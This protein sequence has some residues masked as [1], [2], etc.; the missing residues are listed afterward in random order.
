MA[1][2]K[3]T[4]EDINLIVETSVKRIVNEVF[5]DDYDNEYDDYDKYDDD[6]EENEPSPVEEYEQGYPNSD[7][8]PESIGKSELIHWCQTVGDFLYVYKSSFMG[9]RIS[10]ANSSEIVTEIIGDIA[11]C[12]YIEPTREYDW[13]VTSREYEFKDMYVAILK[14][15]DV[16]NEND[17]AIIYQQPR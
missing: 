3:L 14:L 8:N 16:P 7:F 13:L 5:D 10:A 17:Y 2:I 12:G 9:T 11:K 4:N 15:V 6:E 1:K